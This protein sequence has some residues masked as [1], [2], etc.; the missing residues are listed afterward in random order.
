MLIFTCRKVAI[1]RLSQLLAHFQTVYEG[2]FDALDKM[3][4]N[5][6]VDQST[7]HDFMLYV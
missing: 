6:V 2:N 5:W 7:A 4:Q 1:S 3:V